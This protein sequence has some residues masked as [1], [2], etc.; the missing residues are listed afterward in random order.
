MIPT[1]EPGPFLVEALRGILAQD[2]GKA[3]M[4]IAIVDDASPTVDVAALVAALAPAGRIEIHRN[5]VNLGLARNWNRGIALARGEFVHLLHQDDLILPGFY[6]QLLRGFAADT[7]VGMAF[8]RHAFI[9]EAGQ[10]T[11]RSHRERWRRGTL[12]RW[13]AR[14]SQR[15]RIQCP[16]AI[17]RRSVYEQLGGF[18]SDLT[19][20]LDWEMWVRIAAAHAVWYEPQILACY[21]R[22]RGSETSR[23]DQAGG[24]GTDTLCAI[25]IFSQHLPEQSR[26]RLSSS[27]YQ[28]LIQVQIRHARKLLARRN[29]AS[30]REQLAI[31]RTSLQHLPAGLARLLRDRE[32]RRMERRCVACESS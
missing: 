12:R 26:K 28:R 7:Q 4:Q 2:P 32:L 29:A 1:Y 25:E 31:A 27:A 16:A 10:W 18:R 9:D 23:L 17:V 14:I 15:Q 11:R 3:V 5:P 21:R 19:Y 8:C 13:L 22:H 24:I 6:E 30:A 20:A